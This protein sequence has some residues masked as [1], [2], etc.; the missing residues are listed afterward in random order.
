LAPP[1]AFL[2]GRPHVG[3]MRDHEPNCS[4]CGKASH[5]V[6]TLIAGPG[7]SICNECVELCVDILGTD[8]QW[9]ERLL[10]GLGK[11]DE[12]ASARPSIVPVVLP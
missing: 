6:A 2:E 7:V 3:T 1:V 8:R 5:H 12:S 10:A 4:F 9:R 11:T